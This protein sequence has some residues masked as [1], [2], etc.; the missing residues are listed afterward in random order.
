MM[1]SLVI[2]ILLSLALPFSSRGQ[3]GPHAEFSASVHAPR[4][5]SCSGRSDGEITFTVAGS[6]APF[7]ITWTDLHTGT[8]HQAE[9]LISGTHTLNGLAAGD[10]SIT[11]ED[12]TGRTFSQ[13]VSIQ[14][15]EPLQLETRVLKDATCHG[16]S[17]GAATVIAQGGAGGYSYHWIDQPNR[18]SASVSG[19]SSGMYVVVVTDQNGCEAA[20]AITIINTEEIGLD[21]VV[22]RNVSPTGHDGAAKVIAQDAR[23]R[24]YDYQWNTPEQHTTPDAYGLAAGT[25]QV[26]VTDAKGCK[27]SARVALKDQT[28][29]MMD[30]DMIRTH[31]HVFPNPSSDFVQ[32]DLPAWDRAVVLGLLNMDGKQVLTQYFNVG[33]ELRIDL[34]NLPTGVYTLFL[35]EGTRKLL[36]NQRITRN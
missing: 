30:M 28:Q 19:L 36:I 4:S 21:P 31:T 7:Q 12:A 33:S 14:A 15:P 32:V 26:T 22:I 2:I 1:K 20:E 25:Y 35:Q 6:E 34:H 17:N 27:A 10:Y 16:L 3:E 18:T 11:I 8:N 23:F 29:E 5:V 9:Y 24:Q 13:S